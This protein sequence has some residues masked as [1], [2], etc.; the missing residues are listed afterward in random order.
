MDSYGAEA[1]FPPPVRDTHLRFQRMPTQELICLAASGHGA[2][3]F[4]TDSQ[5]AKVAFVRT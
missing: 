3:L 4:N 5:G 2:G 1:T